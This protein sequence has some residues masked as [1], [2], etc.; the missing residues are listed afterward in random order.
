MD[1]EKISVSLQLL[2]GKAKYNAESPVGD[3]P[4]VT[5]DTHPP[6]GTD[7]GYTPLELFLF[8]LGGCVSITIVN[9]LRQKEQKHVMSV[10]LH[11]VGV[12]RDTNP[13]GFTHVDIQMNI[14]SPDADQSDVQRAISDAEER[15]CPMLSMIKNNVDVKITFDL[16]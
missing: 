6:I 16:G 15:I 4:A 11:V 7:E 9:I 5:I 8:A 13:Q 2:D 10:A 1:S 14:E 3:H 12:L